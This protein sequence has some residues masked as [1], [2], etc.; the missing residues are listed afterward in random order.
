MIISKLFREELNLNDNTL[1]NTI[2]QNQDIDISF[3]KSIET[4]KTNWMKS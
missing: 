2:V 1:Y 4:V 3:K